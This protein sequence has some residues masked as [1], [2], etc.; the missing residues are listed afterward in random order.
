MTMSNRYY[1]NLRAAL[2]EDVTIKLE[3][4]EYH[5]RT[6]ALTGNDTLD[7]VTFTYTGMSTAHKGAAMDNEVI[8]AIVNAVNSHAALLEAL[9]RAANC[10]DPI[11]NPN[12]LSP[13][14]QATVDQARTA[15][16]QAD[17]GR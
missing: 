11:N 5:S 7:E 12:Q 16:G 8:P 15:I 4:D 6:L 1:N 2:A 17:E 3:R 14:E 9:K 13:V 10:I